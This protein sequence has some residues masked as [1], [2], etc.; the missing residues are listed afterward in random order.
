MTSTAAHL[1]H[2]HWA[3]MDADAHCHPYAFVPLQARIQGGSDGF[4]N[5]EP[6]VHGSRC[7]V[8]MRHRPAEVDQEPIAEILGDIPVKLVN[9]L[10]G[11]SLI[12]AND[13]AQVFGIEQLRQLGRIRQIAKHHGELPAFGIRQRWFDWGRRYVG[14]RYFLD[15]GWLRWRGRCCRR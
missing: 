15:L 1:A 11:G 13:L 3:G 12:G 7:I 5:A 9:H 10:G 14:D 8:F 4:N 2:H 6:G